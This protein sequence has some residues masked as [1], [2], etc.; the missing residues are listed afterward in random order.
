MSNPIIR[1]HQTDTNEI[2]DREMTD[3]EYVEWQNSEKI[4]QER[5][6]LKA[7]LKIELQTKR[8]SALAKLAALGLDAD[9]ISALIG[10]N[11]LYR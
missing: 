7:N 11:N 3:K 6:L 5:L 2:I 8:E 1:I 4:E 9:E 10:Q